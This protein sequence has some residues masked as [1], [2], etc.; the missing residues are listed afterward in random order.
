MRDQDERWFYARCT[1]AD[2]DPAALD[3]VRSEGATDARWWSLSEIVA[4]AERFVPARLGE[5]LPG[6]LAGDVDPV[7]V[8]V[9][10]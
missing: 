8:D 3:R 7:A 6:L 4:G 5:L 10:E 2:V 1:A 9:G